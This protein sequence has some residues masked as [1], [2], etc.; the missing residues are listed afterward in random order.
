MDK[1]ILIGIIVNVFVI[2]LIVG[3]VIVPN[4]QTDDNSDSLL[5]NQ[6]SKA[7]VDKTKT[8]KQNYDNKS[9][10]THEFDYSNIVS[11]NISDEL[12]DK[13]HVDNLVL[14]SGVSYKYDNGYTCRLGG[15]TTSF[16]NEIE[17]KDNTAYYEKIDS[18]KTQQGY[19]T[20]IY[21]DEG[22]KYD[23]YQVYID[24]NNLTII[25]SDGYEG[26]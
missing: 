1:K 23:I 3:F 12:T 13:T 25:E 15:L 19:E 22:T 2:S 11:F 6:L 21:K 4:I 14:G 20:H 9:I 26:Q 17:K 16:N 5:V 10:T 7:D 18:D 24:L 8:P